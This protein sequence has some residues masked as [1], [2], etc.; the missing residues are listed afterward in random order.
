MPNRRDFFKTVAGATAGAFAWG[1]NP[2]YAAQTPPARRQVT[3]AGRRIRV[4]DIHAH[5]TVPEVATVVKGTAFEKN[6]ATGDRGIGN[7]QI[8]LIDKEG[9][10]IQALSI[11]QWWWYEV[12]DRS[13]ADRIVRAQNEGL[14]RWVSMHPDRFVAFAST[15][16]QFPDL[17]AEQLDYGVKQLGLRG[18]AIGGHMNGEDLL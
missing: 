13:L 18:A 1:R 12:P 5:C 14:A 15:S 2:L 11:N 7:S 6:A 17:A 16:L 8:E 10:D 3:I 4:V 9:I